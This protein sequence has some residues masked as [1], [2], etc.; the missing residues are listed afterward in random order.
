MVWNEWV[1]APCFSIIIFQ[2]L[3]APSSYHFTGWRDRMYGFTWQELK[4][5]GRTWK[6]KYSSSHLMGDWNGHR[7]AELEGCQLWFS[8]EPRSC[9]FSRLLS[10]TFVC[11]TLVRVA[12]V[13]WYMSVSLCS[14]GEYSEEHLH[15]FF[16]VH[17]CLSTL[18][19]Q[20]AS[21]I[22]MWFKRKK[23]TTDSL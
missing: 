6:T 20:T 23:N 16:G 1:N 7:N 19:G 3:P 18:L 11:F 5:Q 9:C 8:Q 21:G 2:P 10:T 13:H 14:F 22:R 4:E 12:E 17:L 15:N